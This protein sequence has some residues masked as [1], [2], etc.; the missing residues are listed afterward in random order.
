MDDLLDV[1]RITRGKI[2]LHLEALQ[3]NEIVAKAIEMASPLIEQRRHRL[4]VEVPD[5]LLVEGD[6]GR[7]AQIVANVLTNAA[8][9]TDPG[10]EIAIHAALSDAEVRVSIRDNGV[11]IEPDMLW[12]VFDPFAQ[13]RQDSDRSQGGLGLGL[14]I[15][16]SLVEAHGGT[17]TL[18]SATRTR[19]R[20]RDPPAAPEAR[21]QAAHKAVGIRRRPRAAPSA[22]CSWTTTGMPRTCWRCRCARFGHHVRVANDGPEAI[23]VAGSYVPEVAPRPG[24]AGDGRIRSAARLRAQ[25]S[26]RGVRLVALTGYGLQNDRDRTKAAGFDAHLVKP[27]DVADLDLRLRS[28]RTSGS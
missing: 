21:A 25:D 1:S 24:A 17:V 7:L 23:E 4:A 9:Y 22:S 20:M 27:V 26:W 12:R 16:R 18:E 3:L 5:D 15:V 11:G 8:K 28:L 2:Q 6:A 19:E 10:G 14:A 13:E